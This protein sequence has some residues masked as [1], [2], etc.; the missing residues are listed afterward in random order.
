MAR[1]PEL[2]A[3][4]DPDAILLI[5]MV[6]VLFKP[7]LWP[8]DLVRKIAGELRKQY[9]RVPTLDDVAARFGEEAVTRVAKATIVQRATELK[10]LAEQLGVNANCHICG[11]PRSCHYEFALGRIVSHQK[12]WGAAVGTLALNILT[13]PLAGMIVGPRGVG[14]TTRAS[15]ARCRLILCDECADTRRGFFGNLKVTQA[16]CQRH[17]SWNRL[18]RA[19][20]NRY[21]DA[22]LLAKYH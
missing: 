21:F 12:H 6:T 2:G 1:L 8:E 11:G 22:D 10:E 17:P 14:S 18:I 16:D 7:E 5:E 9:G 15:L 20:F 3:S 4:F 19:G 13:V